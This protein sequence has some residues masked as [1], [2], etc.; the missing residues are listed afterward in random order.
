MS[1]LNLWY[2]Q[3]CTKFAFL[4]FGNTDFTNVDIKLICE[5]KVSTNPNLLVLDFFPSMNM[6]KINNGN[7][8]S[9]SCNNNDSKVNGHTA[10]I[11]TFQE[12]E[13]VLLYI[14]QV[15]SNFLGNLKEQFPHAWKN[16]SIK[17]MSEWTSRG[18][19]S[20]PEAVTLFLNYNRYMMEEYMCY[21]RSKFNVGTNTNKLQKEIYKLMNF[22]ED[23]VWGNDKYHC[24]AILAMQQEDTRKKCVSSETSDVIMTDVSIES[25][26]DT[27]NKRTVSKFNTVCKR[28]SDVTKNNFINTVDAMNMQSTYTISTNEEDLL[29]AN[30]D[31][32]TEKM[33]LQEISESEEEFFVTELSDSE[34]EEALQ[35]IVNEPNDIPDETQ[36]VSK[37]RYK[38]TES[39][40]DTMSIQT[41]S[42]TKNETTKVEK[43]E[44]DV[45]CEIIRR[46]WEQTGIN[47]TIEQT[48][49][50][51]RSIA[52]YADLVTMKS[53]TAV[54]ASQHV[55][56]VLHSLCANRA[57]VNM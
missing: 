23:G 6:R 7:K 39:T 55:E 22:V 27:G 43:R 25:Q 36:N 1:K 16:V 33:L 53:I 30:M 32:D 12:V 44:I 49:V 9:T 38:E 40:T 45:F 11:T 46:K 42:Y 29:T 5:R 51:K 47:F 14:E 35:M 13:P 52:H 17:E 19:F 57:L 3:P 37:H 31:D 18:I 24:Y 48:E 10:V 34:I 26:T 41:D 2:L 15:V 8:Q 50:A 4:R 28:K 56:N 54:E 21:R 20:V